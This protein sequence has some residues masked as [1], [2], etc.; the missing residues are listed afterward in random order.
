MGVIRGIRLIRENAGMI[1][2]NSGNQGKRGYNHGNWTRVM[3]ENEG[4]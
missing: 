3:R 2:E 4:K 1:M